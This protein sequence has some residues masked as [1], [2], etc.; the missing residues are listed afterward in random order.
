MNS[1]TKE[2]ASLLKVSLEDAF[3]VQEYIDNNWL[4]DW[5]DASQR[6]INSTVRSVAKEILA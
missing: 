6:K 1:N 4:L 3:K 5:S 2:I